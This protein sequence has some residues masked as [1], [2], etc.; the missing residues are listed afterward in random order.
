MTTSP[1]TATWSVWRWKSAM[2]RR[3]SAKRMKSTGTGPSIT[4]AWM[5]MA[6]ILTEGEHRVFCCDASHHLH[7]GLAPARGET[8]AADV[9][10]LRRHRLLDGE[11]LSR[12][13]KRLP[14][15]QVSPA[16]GGEHGRAQR[17]REDG[18]HRRG[19]AGRVGA[20]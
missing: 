15:D 1:V 3:T 2:P 14:E 8:R 6:A 10:R 20:D 12:E 4:G 9:L 19:D 18:R 17:G 13:R 11:H 7:R 16:G 5:N